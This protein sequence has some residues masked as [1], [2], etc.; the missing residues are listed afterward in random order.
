MFEELEK[1]LARKT[2]QPIENP[3]IVSTHNDII[4]LL[5]E[6]D[7][8]NNKPSTPVE[9]NAVLKLQDE[10]HKEQLYQATTMTRSKSK[11]DILISGLDVVKNKLNLIIDHPPDN[12]LEIN[13]KLVKP[14]KINN[15]VS[16]T[17]W[18]DKLIKHW[19]GGYRDELMICWNIGDYI[20]KYDAYNH[21]LTRV[22]K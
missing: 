14:L 19:F 12:N 15:D 8:Q 5:I 17:Y 3:V 1:A 2:S 21:K 11:R 7:P 18:V 13:G 16:G 10:N 4:R 22:K 20:Y 9:I 6:F